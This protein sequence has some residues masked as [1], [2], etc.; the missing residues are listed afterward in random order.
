MSI[1]DNVLTGPR[2]TRVSHAIHTSWTQIGEEP[3]FG[4]QPSSTR[5]KDNAPDP[6]VVAVGS[7]QQRC[8]IARAMLA[9]PRWLLMDERHLRVD[10]GVDAEESKISWST[11]RASSPSSS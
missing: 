6:R 7:Q 8:C 10:P 5:V 9:R 3:R 1:L 4:A 2:A 11:W